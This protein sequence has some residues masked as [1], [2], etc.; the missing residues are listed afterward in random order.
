MNIPLAAM[1]GFLAVAILLTLLAESKALGNSKA[2]ARC[3]TAALA[4]CYGVCA[5]LAFLGL[6]QFFHL[7]V[8]LA[9][10]LSLLLGVL[11][12]FGLAMGS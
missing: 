2:Y 12:L 8:W 1:F 6:D 7:N 3:A 10:S 4:C 11:L 5:S 9:V